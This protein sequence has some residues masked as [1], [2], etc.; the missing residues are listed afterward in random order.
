M[1]KGGL[2]PMKRTKYV[3]FSGAVLLLIVLLSAC[4]FKSF[5]AHF[6]NMTGWTTRINI[7]NPHAV[8]VDVD[9][10]VYGDYGTEWATTQVTIP[11]EGFFRAF[12]QDIFP[13]NIPQTGSIE[14]VAYEPGLTPKVT[15]M[16]M[17]D[18]NDGPALGGLQAFNNPQKV[19][20]FPWFENSLAFATGIAVFNVNDW[21]IQVILKAVAFDGTAWYSDTFT[22]APKERLI[23][24][25]SDFFPGPIPEDTNFSVHASGKVAGFIIVH[26]NVLSK[27]EAINGVP[28]A[29]KKQ[30]YFLNDTGMDLNNRPTRMLFSPD[31][32][33]IYVRTE[34]SSRVLVIN[35]SS[36]TLE[37]EFSYGSFGDIAL[38]PD[39][40]DL[41]ITDYTQGIIQRMSTRNFQSTTFDTVSHPIDLAISN[42]GRWLGV[43]YDD[44]NYR[45]YDLESSGIYNFSLGSGVSLREC[46]FTQDSQYF[47]T[48]DY[49]NDTMH[50]FNLGDITTSTYTLDEPGPRCLIQN[51]NNWNIYVGG[52]SDTISVINYPGFSDAGSL[53]VGGNQYQMAFSPDGRLLYIPSIDDSQLRV[54]DTQVNLFSGGFVQTLDLGGA[55]IC[56]AAAPN[57]IVF[58]N[59]NSDPYLLRMMF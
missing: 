2:I 36:L 6:A 56:I 52:N 47:L 9:I 20:N 22:L 24:Y 59:L 10:T 25:P 44:S 38:S 28:I 18:Y 31:G 45:I 39:G 15:A 5:I 26:N 14:L 37:Q 13:K 33:R 53:T 1:C 46:I 8:D 51:P 34:G 11:A 32:N 4:D 50:I 49:N 29:T 48:V 12:V 23:G 43:V 21:E 3:F 19:L 40:M 30:D 41:F 7:Q 58:Y 42:N 35:R 54:Y 57:G 17:F 27:A 55:V 16:I